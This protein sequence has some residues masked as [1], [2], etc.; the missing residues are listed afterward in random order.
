LLPQLH[1]KGLSC[2]LASTPTSSLSRASAGVSAAAVHGLTNRGRVAAADRSCALRT[3]ANTIAAAIAATRRC[4][5]RGK[6]SIPPAHSSGH[7]VKWSRHH[8]L[9]Q[10][11]SMFGRALNDLERS[12][13][14]VDNHGTRLGRRGL[15]WPRRCPGSSCAIPLPGTPFSRRHSRNRNPPP[16]RTGVPCGE[17]CE[18]RGGGHR[19]AARFS[20][21]DRPSGGLAVD[22]DTAKATPRGVF[23]DDQ[24]RLA[25]RSTVGKGQRRHPPVRLLW[26]YMHMLLPPIATS[27]KL[28]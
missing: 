11:F 19:P 21:D 1:L 12:F 25:A 7:I 6:S 17:R 2:H 9:Q 15:G 18:R 8:A 10:Q 24:R 22:P 27:W 13:S 14:M 28:P 16:K 26:R 20:S 4:S 3:K 23:F 5:R